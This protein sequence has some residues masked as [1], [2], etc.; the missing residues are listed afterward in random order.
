MIVRLA[1]T[2][3]AEIER[4][5]PRVG[6]MSTRLKACFADRNHGEDFDRTPE[7]LVRC[8][9]RYRSGTRRPSAAGLRV[10]GF[11]H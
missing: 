8:L 4:F 3:E 5:L 6:Q 1:T 2:L 9:R 7:S 10:S 11:S